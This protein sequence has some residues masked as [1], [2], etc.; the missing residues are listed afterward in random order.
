MALKVGKAC[1][2][3]KSLNYGLAVISGAA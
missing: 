3:N 1:K 2:L